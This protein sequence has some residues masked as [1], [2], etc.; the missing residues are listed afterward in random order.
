MATP[1]QWDVGLLSGAKEA[2]WPGYSRLRATFVDEVLSESIMWPWITAGDVV[3]TGVALYHPGTDTVAVTLDCVPPTR[4]LPMTAPR[5]E[6]GSI[7][8]KSPKDWFE[9]ALQSLGYRH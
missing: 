6:P 4:L 8:T 3:V 9:A 2:D 5:F 7:D 1:V